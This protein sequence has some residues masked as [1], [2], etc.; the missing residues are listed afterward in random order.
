MMKK[1]IALLVSILFLSCSN[2]DSVSES[3]LN[4]ETFVYGYNKN[5]NRIYEIDLENGDTTFSFDPT[6]DLYWQIEYIPSTNQIICSIDAGNGLLVLD[7]DTGE[8]TTLNFSEGFSIERFFVVS[9]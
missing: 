3:E 8:S 4:S 9:K 6:V 5:D 2:D 1:K 7:L